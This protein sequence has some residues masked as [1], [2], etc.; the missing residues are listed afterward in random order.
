MVP[1][2]NICATSVPS[3]KAAD[4]AA[5]GLGAPAWAQAAWERARETVVMAHPAIRP[6]ARTLL[7]TRKARSL[8]LGAS[9]RISA[10]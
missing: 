7:D 3:P 9:L 5:P 1:P 2:E 10:P 4:F 8:A 6:N